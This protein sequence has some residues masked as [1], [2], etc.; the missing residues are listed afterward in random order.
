[1]KIVVGSDHAGYALK[2]TIIS[3]LESK[4][5]EVLDVGTFS[6]ESTHYPIYG[7]RV[8]KKVVSGEGD[9]GIAICGTGVGIGIS[10]NKVKGIRA[11]IV[12]DVFSARMSRAHNDANVLAMGGRVVGPGLAL[13]IVEA[14]LNQSFEGE[15]HQKRVELISK[16]E[17]GVDISETP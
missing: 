14:W 11:A 4:N 15:R 6:E 3:Y 9:L 7:Q 12:S 13:E 2:Q 1:M 8:G 16:V 17:E 10:A 5:I